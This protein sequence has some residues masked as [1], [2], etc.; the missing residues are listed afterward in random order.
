MQNLIKLN[1]IVKNESARIRQTLESVL[2]F[3]DSWCIVDTG[4]TDNTV[5]IIKS[6][7]GHIPGHLIRHSI[8]TY[9]DTEII[10]YAATRNMALDFA[11]NDSTFILLLNGDDIL[12]NGNALKTFC[13]LQQKNKLCDGHYIQILGS[14][15]GS[16]D[17]LRLIRSEANLRYT[18]P[19]HEYIFNAKKIGER[20]PCVGISSF[21]EPYEKSYDRWERDTKILMRYLQEDKK[22]CRAVFYLA[23]SYE[24]L[25]NNDLAFEYYEKRSEMGGWPEEVY[26]AKKRMAQCANR[27]SRFTWE[28]IKEMYLDAFNFRPQRLESIY[29]I[30]LHYY[31]IK[32]FT[33]CFLYALIGLECKIPEQDI[34]F[35]DREVYEWK[36]ADLIACSAWY[37]NKKEIGLRAAKK[38]FET[39]S[40]V[41]RLEENYLLY[42]N[43]D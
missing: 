9:L 13:K 10:D 31:K 25:G 17:S 43:N 4:S 18:F 19:T 29:E 36:L 40:N 33:L 32:S 3:I 23:Q 35:V 28:E 2:P 42:C 5:E 38:A 34:L 21:S 20:I 12:E 16:Y 11:S 1:M 14:T 41:K 8:V 15:R 22:N 6:C 24:C 27:L 7:L 37:I 26:E 30:A 39:C